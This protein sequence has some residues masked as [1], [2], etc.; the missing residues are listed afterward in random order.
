MNKGL[1]PIKKD[2]LAPPMFSAL[3][4][5]T[6]V[7]FFT[8]MATDVVDAQ[9]KAHVILAVWFVLYGLYSNG[10][11]TKSAAPKATS[12]KAKKEKA[13]KSQ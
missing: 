10:I 8:N 4:G 1:N 6:F 11:F 12:S 5:A 2:G 9:K 13:K 3:V 7:H